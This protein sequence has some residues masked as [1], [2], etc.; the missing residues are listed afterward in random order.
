MRLA[1]PDGL[2]PNLDYIAYVKVGGHGPGAADHKVLYDY[3][4]MQSMLE[5]VGFQVRLLE[6]YDEV[7][8]FHTKAWQIH[9]GPIERS[10]VHDP[11]NINGQPNYTSLIVDAIKPDEGAR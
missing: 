7:G 2:H 6:F 5:S 3:R 9:D 8:S 1:V 4:S 10:L 11:R